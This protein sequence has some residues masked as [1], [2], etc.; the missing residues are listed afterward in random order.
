MYSDPIKKLIFA[1]D[2]QPQVERVGSNEPKIKVNVSISRVAFLYEKIRNAIDY[3]DEHLLRKNAIARMLKRRFYTE[4]R[5]KDFGRLLLTELIRAR[6]LPNNTLRESLIG[7]VDA[8]IYKYLVLLRAVAP[9]RMT[10]QKRLSA[11]WIMSICATEL[12]HTLVPQTR[13]DAIVECMYKVI[14]QDVDLAQQIVEPTERDVQVYIAIHRALIKS[15]FAIIRY[16]LLYHF[17]PEWRNPTAETLQQ[18]TAHFYTIMSL[19][20]AQV[21]HPLGDKL[22]RFIKRFSILFSIL[23]DVIDKDPQG[24]DALI[25]DPVAFEEKIREACNDRYAKARSKLRRSY[26]RTI[27]YVFFTK[28]LLALILE[29]PYDVFIIKSTNYGPLFINVIFHPILMFIIAA[30][31]KLPGKN[32]T[33]KIVELLKKVAYEDPHPG[34]LYKKRKAFSRS[35]ALEVVFKIV[36][37]IAF[38]LTFGVIVAILRKLNFNIVSGFLFIFFVSVISFFG[39]K[40]RREVKDLVIIDQ[41]DSFMSMVVDFFSIP[42]LRV[43]QYVSEK[44]PKINLFL[45]VLDF[46]IEAPLKIFVEVVEDWTSYQREKKEEII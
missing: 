33:D 21:N 24:F 34:F 13:E 31:I 37:V 42:V 11:D 44:T 35:K 41:K 43:G 45:F 38:L 20:E 26:I 5:T 16:H 40:L 3:K 14:R 6:Y 18:V 25:T 39:M 22:L 30:S 10:K 12:E 8:I 7:D 4:E 1:Y 28:M 19:V 36:Y 15:D 17:V 2:K 46:I 27:I 29:F 23:R 32:N 9:D